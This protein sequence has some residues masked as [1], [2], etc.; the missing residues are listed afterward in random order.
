M[1][2]RKRAFVQAW[3]R[4]AE[5]DLK[6]ARIIMASDVPSPPL[7]T[8]CFHCQQ[9]SEKYLKA[10]LASHGH[11]IPL[12]HNLANIVATCMQFDTEFASVQRTA[13]VLTPY[14][15]EIR[16]PDELCMPTMEEATEALAIATHI[17]RFVLVRIDATDQLPGERG[18]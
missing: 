9:A 4:K 18:I 1:S 7:D 17:M 3:L 13:E 2:D 16:Y 10:Y 15:V 8:V 12:S 5:S 6:S 11:S 14:A